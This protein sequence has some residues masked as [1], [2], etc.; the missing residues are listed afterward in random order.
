MNEK[1]F[2]YLILTLIFLLLTIMNT[3]VMTSQIQKAMHDFLTESEKLLYG[4]YQS[5]VSGD[6]DDESFPP[7][8]HGVGIY[9]FY[10]DPLFLHGTAAKKVFTGFKQKPYFNR[11]KN[12]II[13][14]RDL[15]DPFSPL[16]GDK[17][18]IGSVH[19]R[20]FRDAEA[21][22]DEEKKTMIRLVF[23]E[24]TDLPLKYIR[25]RYWILMGSIMGVI[26][27]VVI[28]I[29]LLYLRNLKFR[30]QIE[31]QERLVMLGTAART[32]T[33]EVKNP[34]SSIRL[35]TSVIRR[36]GCSLHEE[37]LKIIDE[38]VVRLAAMTERIGDFLRHP[39]GNPY[40]TDLYRE[41]CRILDK[42][43]AGMTGPETPESLELFVRIDPDR[44]NSIVDNL[45]NNAVESGSDPEDIR[46]SLEKKGHDAVLMVSDKGCG[47]SPQ[48][49]KHIADPFF[50]T[51]SRGS[52]VGLSIIQTFVQAVGGS[53]HIDTVQGEGTI[54]S[55][56]FPL[57]KDM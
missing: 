31:S 28:Y 46:V 15:L 38:E 37:S 35:Q 14:I 12:T 3:L 27:L 48:D 20:M 44:L 53:V 33:H 6:I 32:L 24:L 2:L 56:T 29:G 50:T 26:L 34:L 51:K 5:Y 55:V 13:I 30:N 17:G 23:L 52:G 54:V 47:I 40:R 42:K 18:Y 10:G 16:L 7:E 25:R 9:N 22:T 21:G 45:L 19:D 41:V 1:R 49:L 43:Q 8:I 36:S 39:E 11:E 4:I 57:M